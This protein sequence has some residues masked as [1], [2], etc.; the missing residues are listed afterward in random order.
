MAR[1]ALLALL[2]ALAAC[3]GCRMAGRPGAPAPRIHERTSRAQPGEMSPGD[4][5]QSETGS[6]GS[7]IPPL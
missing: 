2:A 3:G 4:W 7:G 5:P 6:P 1:K